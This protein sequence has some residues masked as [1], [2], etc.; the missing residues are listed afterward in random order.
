M[1]VVPDEPHRVDELGVKV[2][3][4]LGFTN[5]VTV[6]VAVHPPN[7]PVTEYVVVMVGE[8]VGEAQL[9]QLNVVPGDQV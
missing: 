1:V 8:A 7:I 4:G 9:I 6:C 2:M 5:T 3:V